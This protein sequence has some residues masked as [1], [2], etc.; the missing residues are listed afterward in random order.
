M[1]A[2]VIAVKD[3]K[4]HWRSPMFIFSIFLSLLPIVGGRML[5]EYIG[6]YIE[7][8]PIFL[9]NLIFTFSLPCLVL[10][11]LLSNASI[12]SKE[13][14]EGTILTLFSQP[15]SNASIILGKFVSIFSNSVIFSFVCI[16]AI[17]IFHS[18]IWEVTGFISEGQLLTYFFF[19]TLL[20]QLPIIGL[21]ILTSSIFKRSAA[22]TIIVILIYEIPAVLYSSQLILSSSPPFGLNILQVL[23][24]LLGSIMGYILVR[25]PPLQVKEPSLVKYTPINVNAQRLF[26]F[27]TS[28]SSEISILEVVISI[29]SLIAITAVSLLLSLLVIRKYRSEY[30]E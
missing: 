10:A 28:P 3:I 13:R 29:S 1:K 18:Y 16:L 2:L 12:I 30:L 24:I 26:Y 23:L 4:M 5:F 17:K 20:F 22:V 15:I 9:V 21:T 19:A 8:P 14:S 11:L 6:A 25:M 27:L 7:I